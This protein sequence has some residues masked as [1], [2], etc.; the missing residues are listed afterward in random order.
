MHFS[1][2]LMAVVA[3]AMMSGSAFALSSDAVKAEKDRIESQ[4]KAAMDQCKSLS[5]N[6]KDICEEEAKGVESVAKAELDFRA[7]PSEEH[8]Y[9]LA[10]AKANAA[11]EVAQE[12]CDDLKGNAEDVCEAEAK[13]AHV[14][15]L[16]AAKVAD[17]QRST[18][19][20]GNAKAAHVSEVRKDAAEN[21]R[22]AQYKAAMERCDALAGDVKDKCQND[23]KRTHAQ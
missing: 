13:A 6:P 14:K 19:K 20:Q 21:V 22:E 4:Y 3:V 5:G 17:A 23:A 12:K 15:A 1:P 7:D 9:E 18:D 10:K 2:K 11:Y 8:R 16:E